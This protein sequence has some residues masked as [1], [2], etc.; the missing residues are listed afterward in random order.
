[1]GSWSNITFDRWVP[2]Y[3]H[4]LPYR[5]FKCY[6]NDLMGMV[7][8]FESAKGYVYKH[9]A[10]DGAVWGSIARDY[11]L[12]LD[13]NIRTIKEWSNNYNEFENWLR[14]SWLMSLCSCFETYL[15]CIIK[16][17]IESAPGLLIAVPHAIDGI[18]YKKK[19]ISILRNE[20]L[21]LHIRN[22]WLII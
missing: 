10:S 21:D 2:R 16:E 17:C 18:Y 11:G 8:S 4:S 20:D 14:L 13:N 6:D 12:M 7:T 1:M 5:I 19:G 3:P 15:A 22:C 9:L